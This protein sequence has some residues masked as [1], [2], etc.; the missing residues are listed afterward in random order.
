MRAHAPRRLVC[1]VPVAAADALELVKDSADEVVCLWAAAE[2]LSVG[3]C[4]R[5]FP[6]LG[7][8]KVID[9]LDAATALAAL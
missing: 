4:Y 8:D 3:H 6:Q 2:F 9:L 7:E 1:A 5:S